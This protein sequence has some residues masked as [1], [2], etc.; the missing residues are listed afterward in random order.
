MNPD[1]QKA[2]LF[3]RGSAYLLDIIMLAIV[4]V[5]AA[6]CFSGLFRF[7]TRVLEL[8]ECYLRFE[9]QFQV[10]FDITEEQYN[11]LPQ[12]D[13]ERFD[14][15]YLAMS[16]DEETMTVYNSLILMSLGII[17]CSMLAAFLLLEFVVPLLFKNGQTLGKKIFG[18]A[19]MR[20]DCVKIS[21]LSLFI[22]AILAKFSIGTMVPLLLGLMMLWGAVG[23]I[24]PVIILGLLVLQVIL[25][26]K[27][28]VNAT[29][30]DRM[31]ATVAVDFGSQLI[32][33]TKE[34]MLA[35]K[36]RLEEDR[37]ARKAY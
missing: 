6:T 21:A 8:E 17:T 32:F 27:S 20:P 31:A 23:I 2:G 36:Q 9:Q 18:V 34:A 19:L 16:S 10:D 35:H 7:D 33:D 26:Y 3:K 15:A 5:F 37:A 30:Q 14:Q 11:A 22:R 29:I 28:E 1:I 13:Q 25:T 4:A 24:A 12:E